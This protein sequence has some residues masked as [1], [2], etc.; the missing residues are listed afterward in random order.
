MKVGFVGLGRMGSHMATNLIRAGHNVTVHDMRPEAVEVLV[1]LGATSADTAAG[2]AVD[3]QYV[4]TSLP[5]PAEVKAVWKGSDGLL[6]NLGF[7]SLF[8]LT[9]GMDRWSVDVDAAIP[10][11]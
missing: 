6:A 9:G 7:E 8:N 4:F 10:R 5:G 3:A 2:T 11:Y 1:E